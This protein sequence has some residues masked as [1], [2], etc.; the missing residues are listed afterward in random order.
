MPFDVD[1]LRR[2]LDRARH[3]YRAALEEMSRAEKVHGDL[4]GQHPDGVQSLRNANRQLSLGA[5]EFRGALR[6][7]SDAI[8][9]PAETGGGSGSGL[10]VAPAGLGPQARTVAYEYVRL[11]KA[12]LEAE[13]DTTHTLIY[14]ARAERRLRFHEAAERSLAMARKSFRTAIDWLEQAPLGPEERDAARTRL[15]EIYHELNACAAAAPDV[16]PVL[17]PA[18]ME[19][20]EPEADDATPAANLEEFERLTKRE[21]QVLKLV[22]EGHSTKEIA[23]R[24]GIAFK[25]AACH[26][27]RVMAKLNAPNAAGLVHYAIRAGLVA[28]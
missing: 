18:P 1:C 12:F 19:Q 2:D 7:F 21:M 5:Q 10:V 3:R 25:T 16:F 8:L 20:S 9:I 28:L 24:L 14:V 17:A 4:G 26:R 15:H 13:I 6:R 22:A 11:K 27:S 23:A